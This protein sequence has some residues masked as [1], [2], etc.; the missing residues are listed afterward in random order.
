MG[1]NLDKTK[2][3]LAVLTTALAVAKAAVEVL[4]KK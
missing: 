1:N 2:K 4:S 3:V